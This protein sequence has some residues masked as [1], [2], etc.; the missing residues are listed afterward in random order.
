MAEEGSTVSHLSAAMTTA[1]MT[2]STGENTMASSSSSRVL[3]FYYHSALIII[4][5]AGTATNALILYALLASK[6]HK[7]H[8]LIV[9]QNA[10]DLFSSLMM[11]ITYSFKLSNTYLSGSVGYWLCTL[12]FSEGLVW[13][14]TIGAIFNLASVT[15]ERYL[16]VVHSAWSKKK[17]RDWMIYAVVAFVWIASFTYNAALVFLTTVVIDGACYAYAIFDNEAA[18]KFLFYYTFV[19][20]Y[21][22]I[23]FIFI[24]CY[25]R[26]LVVIRRQAKLMATHAAAGQNTA[27]HAQS[28]FNQMQSSVTKTM[29][30][31]SALYAILWMPNNI[32]LLNLE[33]NPNPQFLSG[34]YY[35]TVITAFLYMCTNPFIYAVKFDPVKEVLLRLIPCKKTSE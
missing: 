28:Q 22:I 21:L 31:V 2:Q 27:H 4:G 25:W 3:D 13:C 18:R 33:L 10:L 19:S 1:G 34:A 35:A 6:Q 23:L 5:V 12:I 20:F 15:V 8:V 11:V 29:I 7:K 30:F 9:N 14:G 32:Y 26:I 16:R 24:F 17:L